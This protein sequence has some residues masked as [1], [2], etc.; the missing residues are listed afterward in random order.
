MMSIVEKTLRV[1]VATFLVLGIC[2][3]PAYATDSSP[4][5]APQAEIPADSWK[6]LRYI[7]AGLA[8]IGGGLGI[9]KLAAGAM[10]G[11]ARQPDAT[12]AIRTSMIIAAALIEG[13]TFFALVICLL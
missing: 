13:F 12:G 4:S 11:T 5:A 1:A 3:T 7:G 6:P 9:G 10:E 2:A 8:T